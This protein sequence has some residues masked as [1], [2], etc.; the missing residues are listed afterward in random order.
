MIIL[1]V[2]RHSPTTCLTICQQC[3]QKVT[4]QIAELQASNNALTVTCICGHEMRLTRERRHFER[5]VVHLSGVLLVHKTHKRLTEVNILNLSLGGVGFVAPQ[6]D[7]QVDERFTLCFHL[8][9]ACHTRIQEDIVVRNVTGPQIIGAE[10][11]SEGR[12]NFD[13]DFYLNPSVVLL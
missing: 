2:N 4:L 7:I 8:D 9:D 5:K 12:Y 13:L 10:F 3:G 6:H 1:P 11:L